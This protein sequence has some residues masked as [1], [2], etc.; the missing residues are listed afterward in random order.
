MDKADQFTKVLKRFKKRL[1]GLTKER[2]YKSFAITT[3]G[4]DLNVYQLN[5]LD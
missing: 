2:G 3:D 5:R 4:Q 1:S